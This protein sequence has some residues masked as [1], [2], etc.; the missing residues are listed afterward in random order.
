MR[1]REA[2]A[3]YPLMKGMG[4]VFILIKEDEGMSSF[5]AEFEKFLADQQRE[6][7]GQRL[8]MLKRDLTGTKKMLEVAVWP[9]FRSFEGFVLEHEIISQTGVAIYIDAFH[10]PLRLAMESVGYAVHAQNITRERFDFE[11]MRIQTITAFGYKYIPF[12]WDQLDKKPEACR[13]LMYQI[14]GRFG[15][16]AGKAFEELDVYERELLRYMLVLHRPL[17]PK[18]ARLCLGL[19]QDACRRILR[20]LMQKHFIRPANGTLHRHF[21]YVLEPKAFEYML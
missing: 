1:E 21:E 7:V 15:S 12:S 14:V 16:T 4:G 11:Q 19:A 10:E 13:R 17:K 20:K 3:V 18:D 5:E 6:A 9:V 8:E 2:H